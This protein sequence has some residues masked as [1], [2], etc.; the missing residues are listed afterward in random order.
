MQVNLCEVRHVVGLPVA[1]ALAEAF[2]VGHLGRMKRTAEL[3]VLVHEAEPKDVENGTQGLGTLPAQV[4]E[5]PPRNGNACAL[6]GP[7]H[8]PAAFGLGVGCHFRALRPAFVKLPAELHDVVRGRCRL[9]VDRPVVDHA[10]GRLA[11]DVAQGVLPDVPAGLGDVLAA[12]DSNDTRQQLPD[13]A[14][15]VKLVHRFRPFGAAFRPG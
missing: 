9:V 3:R 10:H 8:T 15:E 14:V 5:A 6:N 12:G 1:A 7:A 2:E 11:V 4:V 13:V